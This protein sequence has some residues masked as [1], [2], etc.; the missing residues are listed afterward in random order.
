MA[1]VFSNYVP[2]TLPFLG[3]TVDLLLRA[4]GPSEARQFRAAVM[5]RFEDIS[6]H[7]D[8]TDEQHE[9][10]IA[11]RLPEWNEFV[12]QTFCRTYVTKKNETKGYYIRLAEPLESD[13]DEDGDIVDGATLYAR[14]P[15]DFRFQV[16]LKLVNLAALGD[17]DSKSSGSLST[18]TVEAGRPSASSATPVTIPATASSPSVSTAPLSLDQNQYSV[19]V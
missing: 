9:A 3:G 12:R 17:T 2:E 18:S 1:K 11:A 10:R 15:H 19:P 5:K 16:M 7:D 4:L 6:K 13:E 14:A 8:E